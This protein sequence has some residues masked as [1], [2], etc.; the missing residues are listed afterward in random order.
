MSG[1]KHI[2]DL[3]ISQFVETIKSLDE[4]SLSE[5]LDGSNLV[6]GIDDHGFFTSREQKGGDRYYDVTDY[7]VNYST[8][9][10]RAAH[11]TLSDHIEALVDGGLKKGDSIEVEVLYGALPN[12]VP[13][14]NEINRIVF[15][16]TVSGTVDCEK[17]SQTMEHKKSTFALKVPY[18]P[19]G[20]DIQHGHETTTFEICN[21]DRKRISDVLTAE[22]RIHLNEHLSILEEYISRP[23]G[24]KDFTN[25]DIIELPLNMK[26]PSVDIPEWKAL[27][28]TVKQNRVPVTAIAKDLVNEIK[29]H[30]LDC[31]V[32][33]THS[34][35]GPTIEDGGWIEGVVLLHDTAGSQVKLV[36]KEVFTTIKDFV[37]KTRAELTE[38]PRSPDKAQSL[39]GA[40]SVTLAH[41]IGY[42]EL[43]TT[44]AKRHLRKFGNTKEE[45][46]S[47]FPYAE[48]GISHAKK[49]CLSAI[50]NYRTHLDRKLQFYKQGR[51]NRKIS[52]AFPEGKRIFTYTADVHWRTLQTFS[53][54][55][56]RIDMLE[57]NIKKCDSLEDLLEVIAS[58]Q[59]SSL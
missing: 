48:H 9:Y 10:M 8:T 49:H 19:D 33:K 6:F 56:E 39:M 4:Y 43:G 31:I 17:L 54:C 5:K 46:L 41:G 50:G 13:Y 18:T 55:Y 42:P 25:L 15:L 57:T 28:D 26:P 52:V 59:L 36:D 34:Q 16:R 7:P 45:I 58:R 22:E 20:V 47:A 2:E 37:W 14:S 29:Q 51:P 1:I 44:N 21:L 30:L 40:L 11:I 3:K 23:A 35:F 38:A 24:I 53:V 27:K 32:R 12:A